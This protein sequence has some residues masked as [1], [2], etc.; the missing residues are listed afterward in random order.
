[1][2]WCVLLA[3]SCCYNVSPGRKLISA[4]VHPL[5]FVPLALKSR[6]R[7]GAHTWSSIERISLG[8]PLRPGSHLHPYPTHPQYP[9]T[10]SDDWTSSLPRAL[11]PQGHVV[12]HAPAQRLVLRLGGV[13]CLAGGHWGRWRVFWV[14]RQICLHSVGK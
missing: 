8:T 7:S 2:Y 12:G 9:F 10:L 3:D 11:W 13:S 14:A 5:Q 6:R 1:M 4:P